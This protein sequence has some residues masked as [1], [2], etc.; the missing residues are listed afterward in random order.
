[1]LLGYVPCKKDVVVEPDQTARV[2]CDPKKIPGMKLE[3]EAEPS[4][5]P[6]DGESKSAITIT[7]VNEKNVPI[8][9]RWISQ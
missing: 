3:L 9:H 5:I 7:I 6:A 8:P 4:K 1:M 2:H